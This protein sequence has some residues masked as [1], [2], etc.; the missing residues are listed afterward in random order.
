MS[1]SVISPVRENAVA[2]GISSPI[3]ANSQI[4]LWKPLVIMDALNHCDLGDVVLYID[5]DTYPIADLTPLYDR[6]AAESVMLF[7]AEGCYNRQWVKEDCWRVM[8]ASVPPL[9]YPGR[10]SVPCDSQHA[11]ARF[12]LFQKGHY[13]VQQ[14]LNEWQTYCLNPLAT[15]FDRSYLSDLEA[16]GFEQH[17]TEQAI[18]SL[19]AHKYGYKLYREADG[20]GD[21]ALAQGVDAWMPRMFTQVGTSSPQLPTGSRFRNV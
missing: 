13:H 16:T 18:L 11:V 20:F 17:R 12:M 1:I 2:Y 21:A 15:T 7:T 19:L 3:R 5:G 8:A 9:R 14:F 4:S 6:C 10:R